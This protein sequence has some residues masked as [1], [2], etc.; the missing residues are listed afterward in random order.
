MTDRT[1]VAVTGVG[2]ITPLG[3][4]REQSWEKIVAGEG[5]IE[6]IGIFDVVD[7]PVQIAGQVPA[8]E[9]TAFLDRKEARKT[10]RVIQFAVAAT[11]EALEQA[12][13]TIDDSNTERIGVF[14]GTA[15]GGI[16]TFETGVR[17]LQEKGPK[18]VSPFFIPMTLVDMPSGYVSIHFGARG[19]NMGTVSACA[20]GAHAIGEA[21]ETIARGDADVMLAGGVEAAV[22]PAS[23]AG[24]A[25]AGA[26]S[27]R[28]EDPSH[29]SRP[30]DRERDGFVLG[31]G[32][33]ML[34]LEREGYA[35][36][37]GA[38]ILA[39]V[40]GYGSAGDAHHIPQPG[41]NGEGA[42]RAMLKA[43]AR[44]GI[45]PADISYVNAHGTS[46]PL[47][48]KFET[49]ALKTAFGQAMP[50]VSS[51]KGA[52]GHLLGAAP[53]IEAAFSVLAIRDGVIPPTINYEH[54]DPDCDLDYVPCSARPAALKH[55]LSNSFGFG[56]HNAVLVFTAPGH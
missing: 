29:A 27:T 43:I 5:G 15:L 2:L 50:P 54:P 3:S 36:E 26:L 51:T 11:G 49:M 22:T 30:F 32:G 18:R 37:R 4:T 13:L 45:R 56:G 14:V 47:N 44:A 34:V 39:F 33:A 6:T 40:D 41:E 19:P 52:T 35:R 42:T 17:N 53:A 24:F 25:A 23:V 7:F 16:G 48:D 10:D 55:V 21:M 31:E 12:G 8:F 38:D 46:T 9:P 20:S 28:N 1:R